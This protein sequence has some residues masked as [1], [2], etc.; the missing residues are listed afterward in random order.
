MFVIV[1]IVAPTL[2]IP[3]SIIECRPVGI[4]AAMIPFDP[5]PGGTLSF[6]TLST[7]VS[8]SS[9]FW[10]WLLSTFSVLVT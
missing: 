7:F 9:S 6:G 3:L 10:E 8:F 1:I 5:L 4:P 2:R